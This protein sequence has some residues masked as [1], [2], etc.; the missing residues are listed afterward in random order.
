[1]S[2][3]LDDIFDEV[4]YLYK[5]G[6]FNSALE[7]IEDTLES[8]WHEDFNPEEILKF[9]IKKLTILIESR[10]YDQAE[11]LYEQLNEDTEELDI[12]LYH[13]DILLQK[14]L[15]CSHH[16]KHE[17]CACFLNQV[18]EALD[19]FKKGD[20]ERYLE[21]RASFSR[22]KGIA[23]YLDEKFLEAIDCFEE[24]LKDNRKISYVYGI[25]DNLLWIGKSLYYLGEYETANNFWDQCYEI[26]KDLN[27]KRP[28]AEY[29]NYKAG[30]NYNQGLLSQ[31]LEKVSKSLV[32]Y[33]ELK[34]EISVAIAYH[35]IGYIYRH[36]GNREKAL[37][38]YLR[39]KAIYEQRNLI[40]DKAKAILDIAGIYRDMGEYDVSLKELQEY[41][42]IKKESD[43]PPTVAI[44]LNEMG[45]LYLLLGELDEAEEC[46][47]QALLIHQE[48]ERLESLS[49]SHYLLGVLAQRKGELED[50]SKH[51]LQSLQIR[52]KINKVY[53][54]SKSL[55]SLIQINLN[56]KMNTIAEGFLNKLKKLSKE[57]EN[58]NI[59]HL[60]RL[61]EAIFMKNSGKEREI[62]KSAVLF[63]QISKDD[64]VEDT[65]TIESLLNLVEILIWEISKTGEEAILE[66]IAENL[67]KL[68]T[69]ANR[70]NSYVLLIEVML[71]QA[72][73][74][75]V[76][77]K[78]EKAKVLL[79]K[80]LELAEEKKIVQ[81]AI[82]ISNEYDDL[83]N[84]LDMW[85]DFTMKLPSI[86]EKLEL[87]HI[88]DRLRQI[89]GRRSVLGSEVESEIELPVMFIMQS[90]KGI[91]LHSEYFDEEM[92]ERIYD[93]VLMSIKNALED[94]SVL[95]QVRVRTKEYTFLVS[96]HRGVSISYVFIG[97]SY[98]GIKKMQRFSELINE[99]K[100]LE[101]SILEASKDNRSLKSEEQFKL[102]ETIQDIFID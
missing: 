17:E 26:F 71:L 4:D 78:V 83:L 82:R 22:V 86:A 73:L 47:N 50:A 7:K 27:F 6:R 65:I 91:I 70:Q 100:D 40:H 97:K 59:T 60:F 16:R 2:G 1:M 77:L 41:Y 49:L 67:Y 35:R 88:E 72:E 76:E 84:Q 54:I 99:K 28:I 23:N 32:I 89:V 90:K 102:S 93:D 39:S 87:S 5:D 19:L 45:Q 79:A 96:E 52:E 98:N 63:E 10:E 56:L 68:E 46:F 12:S 43:D 8:L 64:V 14:A 92:G 66:E 25:A 33:E 34:D 69:V 62:Q 31:A 80:A 13:I 38:N 30:A 55:K 101:N 29:Y 42:R 37:E 58:P 36:S 74:A 75:L 81:L 9:N 53:L 21:K 3:D 61:S 48:H 57:T 94:T 51:H 85:E 15:L 18:E 11:I 20:N 24:S 44:A 95:N